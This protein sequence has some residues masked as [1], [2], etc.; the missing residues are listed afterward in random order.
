MSE[1][2]LYCTENKVRHAFTSLY[3]VTSLI[4]NSPPSQG[5]HRA[6]GT[7]LLQGPGGALFLMSEVP[8]YSKPDGLFVA[9]RTRNSSK[10]CEYVYEKAKARVRP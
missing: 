1:V 5:H 7:V 3:R 4:R 2:P 9:E 6:L 10:G 8:L